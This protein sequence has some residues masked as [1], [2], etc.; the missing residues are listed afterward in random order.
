MPALQA[1]AVRNQRK[2]QSPN[3][4]ARAA[5]AGGRSAASAVVGAGLKIAATGG[6]AANIRDE[7]GAV[8]TLIRRTN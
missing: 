2:K 6:N 8:K 7:H 4:P 1:V 3:G 5:A